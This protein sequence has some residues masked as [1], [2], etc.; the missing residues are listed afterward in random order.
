MSLFG[1]YVLKVDFLQLILLCLRP[2][3]HCIPAGHYGLQKTSHVGLVHIFGISNKVMAVVHMIV[4][5]V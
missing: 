3:C 5:R 4:Y 1:F 2:G